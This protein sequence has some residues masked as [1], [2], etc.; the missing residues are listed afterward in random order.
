MSGK[1]F[2]FFTCTL[3]V[4]FFF[5]NDGKIFVFWGETNIERGKTEHGILFIWLSF[6]LPSYFSKDAVN[7][8]SQGKVDY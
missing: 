5:E 8:G 2:S 1:T 6:I 7:F 3:R 4:D